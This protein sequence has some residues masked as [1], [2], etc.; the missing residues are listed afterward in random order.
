[1]AIE[2]TYH[3]YDTLFPQNVCHNLTPIRQISEI[4]NNFDTIEFKKKSEWNNMSL[5]SALEA[6]VCATEA[7]SMQVFVCYGWW[8]LSARQ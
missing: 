7:S 1:M 2:S 8:L 6:K 3:F 5:H 4:M